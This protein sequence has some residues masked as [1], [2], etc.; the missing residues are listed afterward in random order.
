MGGGEVCPWELPKAGWWRR[1]MG[2]EQL[3]GLGLGRWLAGWL[4]ESSAR[5]WGHTSTNSFLLDLVPTPTA[6]RT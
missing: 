3:A 6:G 2:M 4:A 1:R 5:P